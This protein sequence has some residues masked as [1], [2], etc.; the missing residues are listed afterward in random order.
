[1]T[2]WGGSSSSKLG[3]RMVAVL[4]YVGVR[5][6]LVILKSI[7]AFKETAGLLMALASIVLTSIGGGCSL[8][9]SG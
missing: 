5:L 2:D 6:I 9:S 7:L 1:M 8:S 3:G 4:I